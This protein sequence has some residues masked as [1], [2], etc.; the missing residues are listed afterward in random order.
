MGLFPRPAGVLN[1]KSEQMTA[2]E[3]ML[4]GISDVTGYAVNRNSGEVYLLPKYK[5]DSEIF[6]DYARTRLLKTSE[7]TT[8]LNGSENTALLK[9]SQNPTPEQIIKKHILAVN[10]V[11][12][13]Y[14]NPSA[15]KNKMSAD[16]AKQCLD[17]L[18]DVQ[19]TLGMLIDDCKI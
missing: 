15:H 2:D 12:E 14:R 19:R 3:F 13:K 9:E 8:L 6:L 10:Q 1:R 7:N 16:A 5:R 4:G 11:R 17:Y 18:V